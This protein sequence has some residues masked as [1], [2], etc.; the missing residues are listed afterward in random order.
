MSQVFSKFPVRAG[1]RIFTFALAAFAGWAF[2]AF[3]TPV[4]AQDYEGAGVWRRG[5][6]TTC[7]GG[8]GQ[9]GGGD[10]NP[11]GPNLHQSDLTRDELREMIACGRGEMPFN[12][13]GAYF[14]VS[15]YGIPVGAVPEGFQGGARF[16]AE[17]LDL[18][19]DFLMT[20]V[21]GTEVNREACSAFYNG[22]QNARA[23]QQFPR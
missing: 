19:V 8:V 12:L 6:C 4:A 18:L 17:D 3:A 7:H 5:N 1:G 16:S 14:E 13:A 15:C 9:G 20:F 21:L 23:C 10:E 22:D 2:V 11:A